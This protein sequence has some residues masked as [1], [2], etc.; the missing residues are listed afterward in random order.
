M[1]NPLN[2][3]IK[4]IF[5]LVIFC[6]LPAGIQG[7]MESGK[8]I[9]GDGA[10]IDFC[11]GQPVSFNGSKLKTT[12][13][14]SV[15]SNANGDLMFYTD[16]VS[17]WNKNHALMPN[18]TKLNGHISSTQSVVIVPKPGSKTIFYIFTLDSEADIH[19]FSHSI[20]DMSHENGLGD[21]VFKNQ[22]IKTR[23]T[24]RIV[25]IKHQN[26]SDIWIIIHEYD[27]D[28]FLAY[29][30]T[31]EGISFTPVISN[32]GIRHEKSKFNTIGYL[33]CSFDKKKLAV[34]IYG[35]KLVQLFDFNNETG[36]ISNPQTI[37]LANTPS[38][39]GIEFSPNNAFLYVGMDTSG[40]I[41]QLDMQAGDEMAIQK[42][43]KLIGR[44]S[45]KTRFGALQLGIDGKIYIAGYKS[46]FLS[47]IEN[48]DIK[49]EGCTFRFNAVSVEN[50]TCMFGLP[51]FYNEYV[52]PYNFRQKAVFFNPGEDTGINRKYIL[53]KVYFDFNKAVFR[54]S[55]V[56][57]LKRLAAH[58]KSH[59]E[60]QIEITG[61]T[62]SIGS[63][64]YND[65][66]SVARATGIGT[67][68]AGKGID[69]AR[70]SYIG[71]GSSEPVSSNQ[72][73]EGRQKN[74]RVEFILTKQEHTAR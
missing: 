27:S 25:T 36:A 6:I 62:D 4:I 10:G 17:V 48:P 74:R 12:E 54:Q 47:V 39:Y 73:E 57:E 35:D 58:L 21:V 30:L 69:P 15:V 51:T 46:N 33:K 71:K 32:T 9:F 37:R 23:C 31:N 29:L 19:G 67:Y 34:A 59:P 41:Y 18:G 24:E 70:I 28:A 60:L 1:H 7:Q 40:Q 2:N 13:G 45:G 44:S 66:L 50:N 68:L 16:G 3:R 22:R 11:S 53:G 52:R 72:N 65:K 14:T 26:N 42:S 56:G 38:P 55:S 8:W 20:V 63:A 61:H 5:A 49:G 64:E 43:L